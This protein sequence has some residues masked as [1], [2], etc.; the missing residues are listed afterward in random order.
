[1]SSSLRGESLIWFSVSLC[2]CGESSLRVEF[3]T[4]DIGNLLLETQA[5]AAPHPGAFAAVR[6]HGLDAHP[7]GREPQRVAA[8]APQVE[9]IDHH[10]RPLEG[11][12]G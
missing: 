10:A 11:V 8:A 1:M 2:L 7:L 4:T 12:G 6:A 9:A 3:S 5:L